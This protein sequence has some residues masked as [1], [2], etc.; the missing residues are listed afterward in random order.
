MTT[1]DHKISKWLESAAKRIGPQLKR[2]KF[3]MSCGDVRL[4]LEVYRTRWA[5]IFYFEF[6]IYQR[7]YL[8]HE[9][10]YGPTTP[11]CAERLKAPALRSYS[12]IGT[13]IPDRE[14]L[15]REII[16]QGSALFYKIH[17]LTDL[18]RHYRGEITEVPIEPNDQYL[19]P[20][21]ADRIETILADADKCRLRETS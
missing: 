11:L 6:M 2:Q 15:Q 18:V 14:Y 4:G 16:R 1:V 19:A 7:H 9:L 10:A 3:G 5:D 20:V 12:I 8:D 13:A 17:S 21:I